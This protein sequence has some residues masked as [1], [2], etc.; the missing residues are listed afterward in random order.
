MNP[1]PLPASFDIPYVVLSLLISTVGAFVALTAAA[2]IAGRNRPLNRVN[3]FAAGVALGGIGIWAMH[4]I[5][6]LAMQ[7][8]MGVGYAVTETLVS[9]AFAVVGSTLALSWVARHPGSTRHLLQGGLV[10]GL[11]VCVMH[12]LGMYGMRFGGYFQWSGTLVGVSVLIALVAATAALF[13]AFS[14][15]GLA[16]RALAA[17]VMGVAVCAMHYTG[18]AAAT[19]ICTSATPGLIPP[20]FGVVAA[21]DLPVLVSVLALGMAFV[22]SVDQVFQRLGAAPSGQ[23]VRRRA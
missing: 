10:L 21:R 18:M 11:A 12:Y 7:V 2:G 17:V 19:F 8:D 20:G 22:I 5:G 23:P 4:F 16:A 15:R 3:L 1:T 13:L 9:L 6:M 14:A